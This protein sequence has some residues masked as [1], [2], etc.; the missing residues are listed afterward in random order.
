MFNPWVV[1][2]TQDSRNL[3]PLFYCKRK[4]KLPSFFVQLKTSN[5]VSLYPSLY[6]P[7]PLPLTHVF[8]FAANDSDLLMEEGMAFTIGQ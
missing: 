1:A 3:Y 7:F 4:K 2:S 8:C 6:F 5:S